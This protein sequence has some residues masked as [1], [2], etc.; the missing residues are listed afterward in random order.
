[1]ARKLL[2]LVPEDRF[3]Y[4][5]F[6]AR[7]RAARD[8]GLEVVVATGVGQHGPSIEA[9]GFRLVPF[10]MGRGRLRWPRELAT[11]ARL[12]GIYRRERPDI[13]HQVALKAVL[14]GSFIARTL[15]RM[16]VVNAPVGMG[17]VFTSNQAQAR[18]LRPIVKLAL[19]LM[20]HVPGGVVV[21][22]NPDDLHSHVAAGAVDPGDAV[23]IRGAGVDVHHFRPAAT[24]APGPPVVTL[25]A[26]MLYDKGVAEF[27]E[28]ARLLKS[29]GVAARFRLAGGLDPG[30]PT[31]IPESV[32]QDWVGDGAVEWLGHQDD[33]RRVWQE[34]DIACLPSYREGLPKSSLEAMAC[35]LPVVTTDV[36][37]CR[38]TVRDEDNGLLVPARDAAA[39][40]AA[41]RRLLEDAPL[42]R[43]LGE[44]G[45]ERAVQEFSDDVVIAATLQLYGVR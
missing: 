27:A 6:L 23:L 36:P 30:N 38:E 12:R 18:L 15:R 39:L 20:L 35:G 34:S 21:F 31:C 1:M 4:S 24:R 9:E 25:V 8:A 42:R 41:L 2:F 19:R 13:V 29:Q 44:R 22:E 17:Y 16:Q 7:A 14:Y 45:R 10:D 3:F 33:I 40:A 37:G 43:R 11:L 26:R 5:H 32:L 28:A